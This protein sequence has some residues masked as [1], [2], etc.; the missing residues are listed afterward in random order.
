M[1]TASIFEHRDHYSMELPKPSRKYLDEFLRLDCAPDLLERGAFRG[2]SESI[3]VA[4][5][6]FS[7]VRRYVLPRGG[8]F[9]N[10]AIRLVV[11]EDTQ[12]ALDVAALF[13]FRTKW[14][15]SVIFEAPA[16][17]RAAMPMGYQDP[18]VER[19][20]FYPCGLM[21][22]M[23]MFDGPTIVMLPGQKYAPAD[24]SLRIKAFNPVDEYQYPKSCVA[25]GQF[26]WHPKAEPPK[27]QH[28][29]PAIWAPDQTISIWL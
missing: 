11:A 28:Q 19:L 27:M 1:K 23:W 3:T 24:A 20:T 14:K 13:A 16:S 10:E 26:P 22:G 9:D 2:A 29:D 5:G 7:A 8:S 21:E 6:L 18:R 17:L 12:L 4:M 25:L 15:C